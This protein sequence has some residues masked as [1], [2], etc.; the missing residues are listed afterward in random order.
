M[1]RLGEID[2]AAPRVEVAH[3]INCCKIP[4][5]LI[6]ALRWA[7]ECNRLITTLTTRT[8]SGRSE[9]SRPDNERRW[10]GVGVPSSRSAAEWDPIPSMTS[11]GGLLLSFNLLDHDRG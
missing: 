6:I 10:L 8:R 7:L 3:L 11:R 2:L 4:I 1:T 5:T 9:K